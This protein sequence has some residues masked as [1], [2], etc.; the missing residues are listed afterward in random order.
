MDNYTEANL[1]WWNEAVDIHAQLHQR[2]NLIY[3]VL[4]SLACWNGI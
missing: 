4:N 2:S 3:R 1:A